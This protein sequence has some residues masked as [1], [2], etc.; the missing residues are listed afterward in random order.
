MSL[1]SR[2]TRINQRNNPP[3]MWPI[4]DSHRRR[5][6]TTPRDNRNRNNNNNMSADDEGE[7]AGGKLLSPRSMATIGILRMP[8]APADEAPRMLEQR[9]V[10]RIVPLSLHQRKRPWKFRR[11][12]VPGCCFRCQP[13][14]NNNAA[15]SGDNGGHEDYHD[16]GTTTNRG[17]Q[18]TRFAGVSPLPPVPDIMWRP[19]PDHWD[20]YLGTMHDQTLFM[21]TTKGL[22]TDQSLDLTRSCRIQP[23]AIIATAG[24]KFN[25]MKVNGDWSKFDSRDTQIFAL[26]TK[27]NEF[28][29]SNA[30]AL[31]A[32]SNSSSGDFKMNDGVV[33]AKGR[34]PGTEVAK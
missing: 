19:A 2:L 22:P 27:I 32:S 10:G 28:T 30:T 13:P 29:L 17:A 12:A 25:S 3:E 23:H 33:L 6:S 7:A 16:A 5:R 1:R 31:V 34:G 20:I 8:M 15:V 11:P 21:E 26:A 18:R 4:S 24:A 9:T 14:P